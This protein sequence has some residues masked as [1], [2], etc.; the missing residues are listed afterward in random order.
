LVGALLGAKSRHHIGCFHQVQFEGLTCLGDLVL[1]DLH[2]SI[3]ARGCCANQPAAA[4]ELAP[5]DLQ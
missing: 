3:V 1:L 4:S 5:A 2:R